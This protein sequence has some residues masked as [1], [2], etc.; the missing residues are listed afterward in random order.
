MSETPYTKDCPG[1]DIVKKCQLRDMHLARNERSL[2]LAGYSAEI[3]S[4]TNCTVKG[5]DSLYQYGLFLTAQRL[6]ANGR[7][8][9]AVLGPVVAPS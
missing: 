2:S 5:R 7:S 1:R 3:A 4:K 9:R 8:C 6:V